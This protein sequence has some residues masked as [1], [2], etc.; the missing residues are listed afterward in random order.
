M[1]YEKAI[2]MLKDRKFGAAIRG[3]A[4]TAEMCEIAIEALE[5]QMPKKPKTV[6]HTPASSDGTFYKAYFCPNCGI[7]RLIAREDENGLISGRKQEYCDICGRAI[8]WGESE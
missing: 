5:K 1:T 8:D 7:K 4:D 3:Y 6:T 2:E